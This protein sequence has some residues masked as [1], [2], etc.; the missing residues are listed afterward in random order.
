ML[1]AY[2]LVYSGG[3]SNLPASQIPPR[4]PSRGSRTIKNFPTSKQDQ[5]A[6]ADTPRN[7]KMLGRLVSGLFQALP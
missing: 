4:P 1:D 5:P 3:E 2:W 7:R 6:R